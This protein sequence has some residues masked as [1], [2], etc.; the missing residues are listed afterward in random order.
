ML[1]DLGFAAALEGYADDF[2]RRVGAEVTISQ[3]G[4][5]SRTFENR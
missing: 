4:D 2:T 5:A 1:D 3:D